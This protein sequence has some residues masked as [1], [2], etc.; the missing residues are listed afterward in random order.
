MSEA[1]AGHAASFYV[2]TRKRAA[3][4]TDLVGD[5]ND[6]DYTAKM[7]GTIGNSIS[8]EYSD[9]SAASQKLSVTVTAA[10]IEVSVAT[11]GDS[12][13]ITTAAQIMA[14]LNAN[15]DAS[16]WVDV[17]LKTGNDGSGVVTAMAEDNLE[18]GSNDR[19][20]TF[21]KTAMVDLGDHK[22]YQAAATTDRYWIDGE[23]I[24]V[25]VDDVEETEGF[26]I[27][28]KL[29]MVIFAAS[30]GADPITVSGTKAI[31]RPVCHSYDFEVSPEVDLVEVTSRDSSNHREYVPGL[32]GGTGTVSDYW[33]V[34]GMFD[35]MDVKLTAV[36]FVLTGTGRNRVEADGYLSNYSKSA[37]TGQVVGDRM[38]WTFTGAVR[39]QKDESYT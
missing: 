17:S 9:P 3:L 13:I 21:V 25:Y 7:G 19:T 38:T 27:D 34:P 15:R 11:N 23:T 39:H 33:V 1:L 8:I 20:E 4:S 12:E 30:Q 29:G 28:Y 37:N 6:L 14:L 36:F 22:H 16:R 5:N 10:A 32:D 31:M 24:T 2:Q 26:T 35:E 18:G